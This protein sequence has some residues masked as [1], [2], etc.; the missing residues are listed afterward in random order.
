[1]I[2]HKEILQILMSMEDINELKLIRTCI[3]DRIKEIGSRIKYQLKKDDRVI[4]TSKH[5]VEEGSIIKINKTRAVVNIDG[6]GHYNV[7]FSMITKA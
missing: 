1:M 4:V 5:K 6:E 7:P 2:E 3:N